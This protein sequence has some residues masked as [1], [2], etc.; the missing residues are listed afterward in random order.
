MRRFDDHEGQSW[1]VVA[2]RESWG[3]LVAIFIPVERPADAR[4][5]SGKG[6]DGIAMRQ[7]PLSASSYEA[8]TAE[9]DRLDDTGLRDLL[10]RSEPKTF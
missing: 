7:A 9:F 2:G 1:E 6:A 8:A 4:G 5:T 10:L 3:A